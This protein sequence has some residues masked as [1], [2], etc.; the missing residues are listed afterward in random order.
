MSSP[1]W[2]LSGAATFLLL[3]VASIEVSHA[4]SSCTVTQEMTHFTAGLPNT[5]GAIGS[6]KGWS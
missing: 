6:G 3:V 5:A 2:A 4:A 1:R